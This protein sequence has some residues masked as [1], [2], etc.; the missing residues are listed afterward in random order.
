MGA[1]IHMFINGNYM[2]FYKGIT[3]WLVLLLPVSAFG[4][5]SPHDIASRLQQEYLKTR[6]MRADFKQV[7]ISASGRHKREGAG[8]LRLAKPNLMRWDYTSPT[9]QVLVSDGKFISMY[10]AA[11]KQ[12]INI[13]ASRYLS[14]DVTYSFF[15]GKGNILRDFVVSAPRAEDKE[16]MAGT[17]EIEIV[18]RR[19]NSQ[20]DHIDLWVDQHSFILK[21]LRMTDKFG[22]H[23]DITFS[24]VQRNIKIRPDVFKYSPPA[25]TEI[26][27]K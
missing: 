8:F 14:S 23:T 11:E 17:Y 19:D 16:L 5:M 12:M 7:A 1:V 25:G 10:F 27:R 24:N 15:T 18:P 21:R 20:I 3:I 22:S 9:A 4:A 26:I 6:T 13:A 2:K